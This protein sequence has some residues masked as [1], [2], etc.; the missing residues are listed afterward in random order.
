MVFKKSCY[1]RGTFRGIRISRLAKIPTLYPKILEL[2]MQ[3]HT[4]NA[5]NAALFVDLFSKTLGFHDL[6]LIKMA[7]LVTNLE[8]FL[9]LWGNWWILPTELFLQRMVSMDQRY[10]IKSVFWS[11]FIFY[12][13]TINLKRNSSTLA[14]F[15]IIS[16]KLRNLI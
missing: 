2:K 10:L 16:D 9:R 4:L 5:Q 3:R 11:H 15:R 6:V 14:Q 13:T 7:G 12:K 8:N 1:A